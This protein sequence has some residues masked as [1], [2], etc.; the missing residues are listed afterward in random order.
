MKYLGFNFCE[1]K[2]SYYCDK[3]E[4]ESNILF[5]KKIIKKYFQFETNTYR[6][7]HLTRNDAVQLEKDE[8]QNLLENI[9]TSFIHNN[10][11][12]P[13]YHIDTHSIFLTPAYEKNVIHKLRLHPH[14]RLVL[15]GQDKTVFK[16]YS[17]SQKCWV[18]T[19]GQTQLLPKSDGYSR[20]ICRTSGMVDLK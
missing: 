13:E 2:K 18:G 11:K 17:F 5:R 9:Y 20:M 6:W 4:D 10:Q 16:Q 3:H 1:R 15:I 7:V 14:R 8:K 12:M 19:G